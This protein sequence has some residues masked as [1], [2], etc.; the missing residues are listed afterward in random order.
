MRPV[1][2]RLVP[3]LRLYLAEEFHLRFLAE[4]NPPSRR[5]CFS[6]AETIACW[7]AT[8]PTRTRHFYGVQVSLAFGRATHTSRSLREFASLDIHQW[9]PK[10]EITSVMESAEAPARLRSSPS[11]PPTNPLLLQPSTDEL[12]HSVG[13]R[14]EATSN[15]LSTTAGI[16][17]STNKGGEKDSGNAPTNRGVLANETASVSAGTTQVRRP[18]NIAEAEAMRERRTAARSDR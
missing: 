4:T 3:V 14:S 16:G 12:G 6:P 13:C 7:N 1:G 2:S 9:Y 15:V 18:A 17:G 10:S 5:A 8:L 11:P